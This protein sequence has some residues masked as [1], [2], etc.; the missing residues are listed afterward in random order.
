MDELDYVHAYQRRPDVCR[1][2]LGTEPRGREQSVAAMA[3]EDELR[4][5]GDVLTLAAEM[6]GQVTGTVELILSVRRR[7]YDPK[8]GS[9]APQTGC[10][11]GR[12]TG[13]S[14]SSP[15]LALK[16]APAVRHVW[17]VAA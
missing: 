15:A 14:G 11:G 17:K 12:A 7:S 4:A 2:M 8:S 16:T 1:W 6:N 9:Q 5:E 10:H 13:P 3:R